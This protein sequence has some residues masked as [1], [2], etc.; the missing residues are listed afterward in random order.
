M[1]ADKLSG[2]LRQYFSDKNRFKW[3]RTLEPGGFGFL[4]CFRERNPA[5]GNVRRFVVKCPQ[6][7]DDDEDIESLNREK[8]WL[9][10]LKDARHIVNPIAISNNPLL[11]RKVTR[12]GFTHP[13]IIIEYIEN[14]TLGD[15][16]ERCGD[17]DIPNRILWRIFLCLIR[18]CVAMAYPPRAGQRE[19]PRANV[20]PNKLA[21]GDMH[22]ENFMFGGL[23][24]N[25]LEHN[26]VPIL[27]LIDFGLASD[28]EGDKPRLNRQVYEKFDKE[29]EFYRYNQ[30]NG[31]RNSGINANV[32][33][34][35]M[36]MSA[37]IHG[38]DTLEESP[39]REAMQEELPSLD[40]DLQL[41]ILRCLAVDSKNRPTLQELVTKAYNA[42]LTRDAAFYNRMNLPN[43]ADET[44]ATI[45]RIV[46]NYILSA[47]A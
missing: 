17:R 45:R 38:M 5:T 16:L 26:L 35:G 2:S 36:T 30:P 18:A 34:I 23:D 10:V 22:L 19:E 24:M 33:G 31:V 28:E 40:N 11:P 8:T 44:D 27:K 29:L 9:G 4:A 37:L 46:Q 14:G 47:K 3:E 42:V 6:D 21:H 41:L 7:I 20:V 43:K 15:F 12:Q 39:C 25:D 13:H 1:S 32:I